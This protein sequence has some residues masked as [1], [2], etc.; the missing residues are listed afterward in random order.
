MYLLFKSI[1]NQSIIDRFSIFKTFIFNRLIVRLETRIF[2]NFCFFHL[3]IQQIILVN[4]SQV[5]CKFN[6][7]SARMEFSNNYSK[8]TIFGMKTSKGFTIKS[9]WYLRKVANGCVQFGPDFTCLCP[10]D[11]NF[12]C[13]NLENGREDKNG[14]RLLLVS[15]MKT[16]FWYI[17]IKLNS[18]SILKLS[19]YLRPY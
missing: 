17:L 12:C 6:Q 15:K 11:M 16:N 10:K 9:M 18:S 5:C 3:A 13:W 4:L 14:R 1:H 19:I 7:V 2:L 8:K